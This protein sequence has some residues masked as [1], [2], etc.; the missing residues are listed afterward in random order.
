MKLLKSLKMQLPACVSKIAKLI[1]RYQEHVL[2][3]EPPLFCVHHAVATTPSQQPMPPGRCCADYAVFS[4]GL[5]LVS[6]GLAAFLGCDLAL[7]AAQNV[8][9][10]SPPCWGPLKK[11]NCRT[12]F[13]TMMHFM[14]N[15]RCAILPFDA[16]RNH[17][18]CFPWVFMGKYLTLSRGFKVIF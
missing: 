13:K 7:Q 11:R 15:R 12:L 14:T 18:P 6:S 10:F 4:S 17:D 3:D 1:V 8:H 2:G 16:F 9:L 5:V